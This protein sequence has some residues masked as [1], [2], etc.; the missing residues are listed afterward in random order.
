[1]KKNTKN[2]ILLIPLCLL[3]FLSGCIKETPHYDAGQYV[4][5]SVTLEGQEIPAQQLYPQGAYLLLAKGGL[6]WLSL[7]DTACAV[8]WNS[9]GSFFTL[10]I[11]ELTAQG[12]QDGDIL[13]LSIDELG[14]VY[15]FTKGAPRAAEGAEDAPSVWTELQ[16]SWN[17]T[18]Q[19]R[20]WFAEATGEWA[21]QEDRSM[22]MACVIALDADGEGDLLLYNDFYS[23]DAPLAQIRID[24][25]GEKAHCISGH[26]M[27]Y[28]VREWGMTIERREMLPS[29]LRDS[30]MMHP[31]V[32]EY[33]HYYTSKGEPA[34]EAP[35]DTL[36]LSGRCEDGKGGFAYSIQLTRE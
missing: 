16:Q 27:S 25:S 9:T 20:A 26:F 18:W 13:T 14:V 2:M 15:E 12:P 4:L 29:E 3:L 24:C 32:Y 33:G 30:I 11:N 19:G 10:Q 23:E 28:P 5:S 7:G 1:M 34:E 21:D 31:D 6:G 36:I 17:G 22:A 8:K 35:E